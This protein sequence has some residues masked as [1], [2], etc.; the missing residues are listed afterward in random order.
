MLSSCPY[1]HFHHFYIQSYDIKPQLLTPTVLVCHS[2]M[3]EFCYNA[4]A[5][6][7]L[8]RLDHPMRPMNIPQ[9][10]FGGSPS[11]PFSSAI[12]TGSAGRF[13]PATGPDPAPGGG[14]AASGSPHVTFSPTVGGSGD[15]TGTAGT[16][17]GTRPGTGT[18]RSGGVGVDT[19]GLLPV[20]PSECL[21]TQSFYTD[22]VHLMVMVPFSLCGGRAM[23]GSLCR[24]LSVAT[25]RHLYDIALNEEPESIVLPVTTSRRESVR[26][27]PTRGG[28]CF[29][30][31]NDVVRVRDENNNLK[32]RKNIV[33]TFS[34]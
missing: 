12:S 34:H 29:D 31:T 28:L 16:A 11:G 6:R 30:A 5:I 10:P 18:G 7:S 8:H 20:F 25:G 13:V 1:S 3:C 22:G 23:H 9:V 32:Y 17:G 19:N 2:Q 27:H 21:D 24:V 4:G 26:L 14:G 33:T 15:H